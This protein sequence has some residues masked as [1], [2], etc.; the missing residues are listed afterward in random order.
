MGHY[1]FDLQKTTVHFASCAAH[2]FHGPKGVGFL[3]INSKTRI[4]PFIY[5]GSQERNMRGGTENLYGIIGLAKAFEIAHRDME[6]NQEYIGGL[7]QYMIE[8]LKSQI[9]GVEFNGDTTGKAL[10]TVL[11]ASF[12]STDMNEMLLFNLDIAG[13]AVSGGSAC[14][15]G[16]D[17]GS[18][19]LKALHA[20]S[21]R[22]SV[23]FSFSKHNTK[24][25]IDFTLLQLHELFVRKG[26][27]V[28]FDR[29]KI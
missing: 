8:R 21:N 26:A 7:K 4:K 22:P 24:E 2:K 27:D 12:P 14:S 20:D 10:Y 6:S 15:S 11:N 3:Y 23:R 16:S 29:Q 5:G 9:P 28:S 18:H 1:K 17:V 25:E 13:I 19:V